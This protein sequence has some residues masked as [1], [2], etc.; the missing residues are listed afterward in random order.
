MVGIVSDP[1]YRLILYQFVDPFRYRPAIASG[2][3][4]QIPAVWRVVRNQ[5]YKV[6]PDERYIVADRAR[7]FCPPH[8]QRRDDIPI[9]GKDRAEIDEIFFL[10]LTETLFRPSG[11]YRPVG[12]IDHGMSSAPRLTA[13]SGVIKINGPGNGKTANN[14]NGHQ[15]FENLLQNLYFLLKNMPLFYIQH[16]NES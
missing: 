7:S 3:R 8:D 16:V 10:I 5:A 1:L 13:F 2:T 4:G 12:G 11:I 14:R 9:G 6:I 15:D